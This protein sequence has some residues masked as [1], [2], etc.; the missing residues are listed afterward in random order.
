MLPASHPAAEIPGIPFVKRLT[1]RSSIGAFIG[2]LIS[3]IVMCCPL[4][5]TN[6]SVQRCAGVLLIMG[7]SPLS[8]PHI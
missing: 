7:P 2:L 6:V 3:I 5:P 1:S 4:D 8:P